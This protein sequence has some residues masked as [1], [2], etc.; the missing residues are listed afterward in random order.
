MSTTETISSIYRKPL[1]E[2]M[3]EAHGVHRKFH[4]P[5]EI[6]KS[7]L[8]SVKTGHCPEDCGYCAQS[9]H[10]K[11][12]LKASKLMPIAD[13]LTQAKAAKEGGAGR[14]C[15]GSSGREV[16]DGPEFDSILEMVREVKALGLETCVT[17]GMLEGAQADK[18]KE[19]GLD[20]Y[21]HNID[22]S[23]SHYEKVISTRSY[24]ERLDTLRAVRKSGM[25]VCT[26]GILGMGE[27]SDDRISFIQE[28]ST[29]DPHP[30]SITINRLVPIAGT[31]LE[32]TA[33]IDPIEIVRTIAAARITMPSAKIRLSAGLFRGGKLHIQRRKAPHHQ[34]CRCGR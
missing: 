24:D 17:L 20:Y 10:Y 1:M 4:K 9:A 26:G 18:L 8:L 32:N 14:F 23:R 28:L 31:P 16:K 15:M 33:P 7:V 19:A 34:K 27:S 2:L 11:T 3:Y 30:E 25:H 5:N 22:S 29:L 12:D 21:N 6:Q 13:V